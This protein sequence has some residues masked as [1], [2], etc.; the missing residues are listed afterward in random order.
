MGRA[1]V[2]TGAVGVRRAGSNHLGAPLA[3]WILP[4]HLFGETPN[5]A[6][7]TVALP[8]SNC[9]VTAKMTFARIAD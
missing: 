8:R 7:G 4:A 1:V 3:E 6:T 9:I 2:P 5:T